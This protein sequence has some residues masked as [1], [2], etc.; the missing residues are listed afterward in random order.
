MVHQVRI[1]MEIIPMLVFWGGLVIAY[2]EPVLLAEMLK[3]IV[4][5][6]ISITNFISEYSSLVVL[7]FYMYLFVI[8]CFYG[9]IPKFRK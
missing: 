1:L 2:F 5:N 3:A 9:C 8:Y 4:R 7:F 6:P